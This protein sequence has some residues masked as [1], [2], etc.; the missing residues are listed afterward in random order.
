M[1]STYRGG[2]GR[3]GIYNNIILPVLPN[4]AA[5]LSILMATTFASSLQYLTRKVRYRGAFDCHGG[6]D[7]DGCDCDGVCNICGQSDGH[8]NSLYRPHKAENFDV[9]TQEVN[10]N[11]SCKNGLGN[12]K[13]NNEVK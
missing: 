6:G 5:V 10:T 12:R 1:D 4:A 11:L 3:R 13:K 9:E 7:G 8:E 2:S